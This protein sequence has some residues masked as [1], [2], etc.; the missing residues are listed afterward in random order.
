MA[1][2][3]GSWVSRHLPAGSE[4]GEKKSAEQ[5]LPLLFLSYLRNS[6]AAFSQRPMLLLQMEAVDKFA[7]N[8]VPSSRP[9][10]ASLVTLQQFL[11]F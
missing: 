11:I 5:G 1:L 7:I 3:K 9:T 4:G 2:Q 6:K 8:L 10:F